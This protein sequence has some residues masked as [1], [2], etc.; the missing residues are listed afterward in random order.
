[1]SSTYWRWGKKS[2]HICSPL[3]IIRC[4]LVWKC[5]YFGGGVSVMA[6]EYIHSWNWIEYSSL[7][8]RS[9]I[10]CLLIMNWWL[11]SSL[12]FVEV[13]NGISCTPSLLSLWLSELRGIKSS[14]GIA[15]KDQ[16]WLKNT[17]DIS[18]VQY[19]LN[20][21]WCILYHISLLVFGMSYCNS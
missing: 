14:S 19:S 12:Y 16:Q 6:A 21:Y 11:L 20:V 10:K 18:F 15:V 4:K 1:M 7:S 2:N 8:Y 9:L 5:Q 3:C 17:T 13:R